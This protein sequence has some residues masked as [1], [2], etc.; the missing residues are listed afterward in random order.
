ML[1]LLILSTY[2]IPIRIVVKII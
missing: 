1:M 2:I